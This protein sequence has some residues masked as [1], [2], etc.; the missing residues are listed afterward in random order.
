M[1]HHIHRAATLSVV[2]VAGLIAVPAS[3]NPGLL[4]KHGARPVGVHTMLPGQSPTGGVVAATAVAPSVA[5]APSVVAASSMGGS[6][7]FLVP[8]A[9]PRPGSSSSV[10]PMAP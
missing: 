8:M 2:A 3:A 4:H 10:G 1:K 7:S 6:P 9:P 5:G